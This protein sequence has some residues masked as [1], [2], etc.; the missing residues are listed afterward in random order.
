MDTMCSSA[1]EAL[2]VRDRDTYR[3]RYSVDV[4][5]ATL[6]SAGGTFRCESSSSNTACTVQ[7]RGTV[8]LFFA[9][10]WA[11]T[12]SAADTPVSV[13]DEHFM[14]FGVWA[15]EHLATEEWSF[16]VG[17]GPAGS[18][19]RNVSAV[20]G[21]ATYSGSA[22]GRFAI[23]R[24]LGVDEAGAFTATAMLSADFDAN[25]L[26]GALTGFGG[27]APTDAQ[28]GEDAWTVHLRTGSISGGGARGTSAWSIGTDA[29]EGGEWSASFYSE[30]PSNE[31]TGVVPY[32]V[33]GSFTAEHSG[34]AKMIGAFGA[35]RQ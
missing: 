35:H 10:P 26:S 19:E 22:I 33:A 11:F 13:D 15:R 31:R 21:N 16:A 20:S 30:L 34:I 7:R 18:R 5:D 4:E 12:P 14:W 24:E 27:G 17:H 23:D 29:D 32:G 28:S 3:L 25:T 6:G 2:V 9:G 8:Q 1:A